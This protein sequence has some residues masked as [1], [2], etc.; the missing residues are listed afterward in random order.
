M[1]PEALM[2]LFILLVVVTVIGHGIWVVLAWIVR[3]MAGTPRKEERV[4]MSCPWCDQTTSIQGGRCQICGRTLFDPKAKSTSELKAVR[5]RIQTWQNQGKLPPEH[6]KALLLELESE[7]RVLYGLSPLAMTS[8]KPAVEPRKAAEPTTTQEKA[9]PKPV[10]AASEQPLEAI[11]IEPPKPVASKRPAPPAVTPATP[12]PVPQTPPQKPPQVAATGGP[13]RPPVPAPAAKQPAARPRPVPARPP[14]KSWRELV[15]SFLEEREIPAVELFGVLLSAPLIVTGAVIFVIY[16]WETLQEYPVLKFGA[17]SGAT[18]A[19]LLMGLLA[20]I[21]WQL[22]TTGRGLLGMSLLLVPLSFL[23]MANSGGGW[24]V[25]LAELNA[26]ALFAYLAAQAGRVL[27][28]DRPW[29]LAAALLT[30]VVAIIALSAWPG[31]VSQFWRVGLFGALTVTGFTVPLVLHRRLMAG[32]KEVGPPTLIGAFFLL[33]CSLFPLAF[34][35]GLAAKIAAASIGTVAIA[36]DALSVAVSLASATILAFSLT[37]T[38]Q[39]EGHEKLAS[40]RAAATAVGLMAVGGMAAGLVLA[41]PWPALVFFVALV[42][43]AVLVWIATVCQFP[44]THAGAIAAG[45]AACLTGYHLIVGQLPWGLPINA[46]IMIRVL[47]GGASA[48]VLVGFSGL[49]AGAAT[50]LVKAE[51]KDDARVYGCATGVVAVVSLVGSA[52]AGWFEG[53]SSVP[54]ALFVFAVYGVACLIGNAWLRLQSVNHV[55][56]AL[57]VGATLWGLYWLVPTPAPIWAA[58]LGIEAL[59]LSIL[60]WAV[61]V[62]SCRRTTNDGEEDKRRQDATATGVAALYRSAALDAADWLAG[63]AIV[64]AGLV[65]L[66]NLTV[67]VRTAWPA[68]ALLA[69]AGAWLVGAWTRESF[70]RTWAASATLLATLVHTFVYCLPGWLYQPWLDAVLLHATLGVA[71]T[72]ASQF[73]FRK[74]DHPLRSRVHRVLVE[75]ISQAAGLS[76]ALALPLLMT[77]SWEHPLTLSLCLFWLAA[78]WLVVA[79]VNRLPGLITGAQAVMCLGSIA[80]AT[81]WIERFPWTANGKV[82]LGD[83]RTWQVYGVALALLALLWTAS[84]VGLRRI[85][86]VDELLTPEWPSLDRVLGGFLCVVQLAVV[87]GATLPAV[88]YELGLSAAAP[89]AAWQGT[90]ASPTGWLLL[91]TLIACCTAGAWYRWREAELLAV[92]AV[93]GAVPWLLAAGLGTS[94]DAASVLR[95]VAGGLLALGTAAVCLRQPI[96]TWARSLGMRVET[97]NSAPQAT[98][99]AL[100]CLTLLPV[101]G[102]TL[103]SAAARLTGT[104]PKGPLAGTFF[105]NMGTELSYLVPLLITTGALVV[106]AWRESSSGYAF[107]AGLVMKLG[108][109]LACLLSFTAW[110]SEQW[111]ILW[112][113]LAIASAGWSAAWVTARR[114]VDVW[115]EDRPGPAAL[116]MRLELGMGALAVAAVLLPGMLALL[117]IHFVGL[118]DMA[119]AAGG[120]LGWLAFAS[121]VAAAVYRQFGLGRSVPADL[122]GLAGMTLIALAGCTMTNLEQP[123]GLL[124]YGQWWGLHTMMIGWAAYSMLIALSTWWLAEHVRIPEAEGPPQVL[125]RAANTWVIA[126]GAAAVLLGLVTASFFSPAEERL[127]GAAAI[128]LA[129]A[130]SASMAVWRRREAWAF[131]SGL[132]VNVAAS[133]IVGYYERGLDDWSSFLMLVEANVIAGAVVALAWLAVSKRLYQLRERSV[134]S[135]PL[136]ALQIALTSGGAL[137]LAIPTG[138]A[139][140]A[141]PG[142]LPLETLHAIGSA[143]GAAAVLL[144]ALA[145]GWFL[146]QVRREDVVH[147]IGAAALAGG[148]LLGASATGWTFWQDEDAWLPYHVAIAG[149]AGLGLAILALAGCVAWFTK[150]EEGET[151]TPLD[152]LGNLLPAEPACMWHFVL[153]LSASMAGLIWCVSDPAR[154]YWAGAVLLAAAVGAMVTALWR[155]RVAEIALS[156]LLLNL[157]ANVA[158]VAW[159]DNSLAGL[160]ETNAL[161]LAAGAALWTILAMLLP[162]RVARLELGDRDYSYAEVALHLALVLLGGLASVLLV[163]TL[164][165]IAHPAATALTWSAVAAVAGVLLLRLASDSRQFSLPGLYYLGLIALGLTL[166]IQAESPRHL[167]WLAGPD[168]ACCALVAAVVY[169]GLQ[170]VGVIGKDPQ[171]TRSHYGVLATQWGLVGT[172]AV[173]AIATSLDSGFGDLVR[174]GLGRFAPGPWSGPMAVLVLLPASFLMAQLSQGVRATGWRYATLTLGAVLLATFGWTVLPESDMNLLN[175]TVVLLVASVAMLLVVGVGLPRLLAEENPWVRCGR[176]TLIGFGG[177]A[178][179]ALT[180]ILVQ[181]AFLFRPE[182]GAPMA[183]W[184]VVV[185]TV[186]MAAVIVGLIAMAVSPRRDPLGLSEQGRTVYVYGAEILGGLIALHLWLTE[187]GLFRLGIIEQ[188]WM[189]IVIAIA[190]AGAALSEWFQRLG[191]PVLSRPLANTAALLPL[192]PAVAYWIPTDVVAAS[193][194]AGN[195]PAVW[196]CGSL[197]YAVLATTQ[198]SRLYSFLALGTLAASFC[199]LWQKMDLGLAEHVQLYGIPIGLAILLAEQ[200]HHRELKPSVT[201]A[202]RYLALTCI[203][204]TSSAEFL[205]ELGE[206]IWLPLGLIGLAILGILGGIF[207]RI[208]SF[209]IVGFTSLALVLGALV[210]HATVDQHQIWVVALAM[211][212]LGIPLL[213]FFMV[214]EKKKAQILAAANR[215]WNWERRDVILPRQKDGG[216]N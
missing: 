198:R 53:G 132:G 123:L 213:A 192:V 189:L 187:P 196:F 148:A 44:W 7:R 122:A 214:F 86:A 93:A 182:V 43:A 202:M 22:K 165:G 210:Y 56:L 55:G 126:A 98:R 111:A 54:L 68:V 48:A 135:S 41:W 63:L 97:G 75:P 144:A 208:R 45:A 84:R 197:F 166:D 78:I 199:L 32:L 167:L 153:T 67:H 77:S 143:P 80:A 33:G 37:L 57:L 76:S 176:N 190:F 74:G 201:S 181:E 65:L 178:A 10:S 151:N 209:V 51:R 90:V 95:W 212:A 27:V 99:A 168:L 72:L 179:A 109:V 58:V 23:A 106:L 162:Q 70:E 170:G 204:L 42:D 11:V 91:V 69:A 47:F 73:A 50:W 61:A 139:L 34:A 108:L 205:W 8:A 103:L 13:A 169:A 195:S 154:P 17:F 26:A 183:T 49:L 134:W 5:R 96:V 59:G 171:G 194:L 140:V 216:M 186:T 175:Q 1:P 21:R 31:L 147:V 185:V 9:P 112:Y 4:Q 16:F 177:T 40:W 129:S 52:A 36:A 113:G 125:L 35:L 14:Q 161:A 18:V 118:N 149:W 92:L 29:H 137:A 83:L 127:W 124:A 206:T 160:V 159:R 188:Y 146:L 71:A 38:R 150:S 163:Q 157:A 142:N 156:G 136:L 173:L 133:F 174:P 25:L 121:V 87:V 193:P 191:L 62:A 79:F 141:S 130:A 64:V 39:L 115:R 117:D 85:K 94:D 19:S 114:Q 155:R 46:S 100:Q 145:A 110:G 28:P 30:P 211:L 12:R 184:A 203:Y 119:S 215:F 104:S 2:I 138:L 131:V 66:P 105:H 152:R 101:L 81:A 20:C 6:A 89:A 107:S 158:W 3:A 82:D 120:W 164:A 116:L 200:I 207:L 102:V 128:G 60:G 180:L 15:Q 88:G 24:A 172:S